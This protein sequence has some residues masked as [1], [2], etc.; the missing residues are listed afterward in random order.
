MTRRLC[1]GKSAFVAP[2]AWIGSLV[3]L[4]AIEQAFAES[5]PLT[6]EEI[7]AGMKASYQRLHDATLVVEYKRVQTP[8]ASSVIPWDESLLIKGAGDQKGYLRQRFYQRHLG[9]RGEM[10]G[11]GEERRWEFATDGKLVN[12]L[13]GQMGEI[14]DRNAFPALV[15][16]SGFQ[17][18]SYFKML[19]YPL[20]PASIKEAQER[21]DVIEW[22]P[23]A[24]TK[25]GYRVLAVQDQVDGTAC[26]MVER[27]GEDKLWIDPSH[28]FAVRKREMT[29][30]PKLGGAVRK[31]L[32]MRNLQEVA[33]GLWLP[34]LCIVE[35]FHKPEE[36]LEPVRQELSVSRIEFDAEVPDSRYQ[37]AF[38]V[39]SRVYDGRTKRWSRVLP[40]GEEPLDN[41]ITMAK[42]QTR[43]RSPRWL[44][45]AVAGV[46][47]LV[48][49]MAAI[50]RARK[51][52]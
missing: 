45:W 34:F 8:E 50:A 30:G 19:Y 46:A 47:A 4:L 12:N 22:L 7:H 9:V 52:A 41:A 36:R 25:G 18:E 37:I 2:A 17:H 39:G 48:L 1:S 35:G 38:P 44:P 20:E 24:L 31:R 28:G 42:E 32:T 49:V 13:Q 11:G 27:P 5:S 51:N 3:V 10:L 43:R 23:Y 26:V 14:H 33:P 15:S 16:F 40:D 6:L 29:W 21:P